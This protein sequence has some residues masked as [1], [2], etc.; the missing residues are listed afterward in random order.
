[1]RG[2]PQPEPNPRLSFVAF[3][4]RTAQGRPVHNAVNRNLWPE[5]NCFGLNVRE[6]SVY[7]NSCIEHIVDETLVI[8]NVWTD[9]LQQIIDPSAQRVTFQYFVDLLDISFEDTEVIR[10]MGSEAYL[11]EECLLMTQC[12]NVQDG[13]V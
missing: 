7:S 11:H 8:L 5:L 2:E 9:N 4:C 12:S 6:V 3:C 1:M 10:P 13:V